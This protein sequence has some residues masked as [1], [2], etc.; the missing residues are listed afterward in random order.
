MAGGGGHLSIFGFTLH[1]DAKIASLA[2]V[3]IVF[4]LVAAE[5]L[6]EMMHSTFDGTSY[7]EM[8][9]CL[10]KELVIM[11]L[12]SFVI[13]MLV[14]GASAEVYKYVVYLVSLIFVPLLERFSTTR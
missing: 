5:K 6:L 1:S 3:V 11:G 10:Y 12:S 2:F 8:V 7:R 4:Y 9:Q 14:A 13:T